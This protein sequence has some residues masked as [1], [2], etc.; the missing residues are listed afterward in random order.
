MPDIPRQRL[1]SLQRFFA[2]SKPFFTGENRSKGRVLVGVLLGLC[3][4]VGGVQVLMSYAA[5][6]F[7]SALTERDHD[8]WIRSF[9]KYLGTFALSI[10]IGVFYRYWQERLSLAW[11]QWMTQHLIKRYFF[12]RAYYRLRSSETVDNPDQRIAEDVRL[13]TTGTLNFFLILINSFVTLFGFLGV[14]WLISGKL[15]GV[16]LVYALVGTTISILVGRRLVGLHFH[17]YQKEADFRYGLIRVRENAES[18]AFFRGEKNEHR[19]QIQRFAAV[20][21]NSLEII[22]WNRN[23]GFF[24]N[25]Y[26][27]LALLL[28]VMVVGPLYMSGLVEFGVVTQAEGAFAQ[29][30]IAL[31]VIITQFENLSAFTAGVQRLGALWDFLDEYDVEEKREAAQDQVEETAEGSRLAIERLTV[32]TP[33]GEKTLAR[34]LS[35]ELEPGQSLFITGDSGGGKSSLLRTIAG[36]WHAGSG[37]IQRPTLKRMMFLPQKPYMIQGSLRAQ[38]M[39]PFHESDANDK[40]IATVLQ[41]VNLEEILTRVDGDLSKVV[42]WTNILSLGE[43]QRVSF[44]RLFL[45]K[46]EVAFLDE[47]T[48]A[49][50]ESNERTLYHKLRDSGISFVS[51]GHRSTLTE[52]HDRKLQLNRDGTYELTDL[53]KEDKPILR[54][55][56]ILSPLEF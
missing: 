47:A 21:K 34:N 19:D 30:L 50:D 42:D 9:W 53:V 14:L 23:L 1:L 41:E 39:Y 54:I 33:G 49:L 31:S 3:V 11:R 8:R 46:P 5:R 12:N 16:L 20:L 43:Q 17:Q 32:Q 55:K 48:S 6:D 35:F 4:T 26:N 52:F 7:I 15:V 29:V 22:N 18:I 28:P 2:I 24:I 10:P 38:L 40:V 45:K 56:P 27:Y 51:V 36:L 37:S 25:G 13:F 44:A